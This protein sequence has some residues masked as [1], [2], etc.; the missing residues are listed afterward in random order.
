[1]TL[2][3]GTLGEYVID[4]QNRR[5][6]KKINGTLVQGFLYSDQLRIVAELD[7][8]GAVVS[9]FVYGSKV[10][11]PDYM[12]KNGETYRIVSDHIGSPRLGREEKG[13][14]AHLLTSRGRPDK[15]AACHGEPASHLGS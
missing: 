14:A 12:V 15:L 7:G 8:S 3:D 6:G 10:N 1:M 5:V 2:P 11:V 9:R 4:G 13:D